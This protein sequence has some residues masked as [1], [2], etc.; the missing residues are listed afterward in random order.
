MKNITIALFFAI[1]IMPFNIAIA[2]E[3]GDDQTLSP[4]FYV[5]TEGDETENLP[6]LHTEADVNISGVIADVKITQIYKNTGK[7]PIEAIYVFPASTRAAV[8]NMKMTLDERVIVAQIQ[9]RTQARKTYEKAK[10]AGKSAS[11]LE[12]QRPNVFQMNIANIL[13]NDTIKVE[14]FYTETLVPED[15]VYEFVYPTV[16]GPRYSNQPVASAPASEKWIANPYLEEG[17]LPPYTF[18]IQTKIQTGIPIQSVTC[19]SHKVNIDFKAK[20]KAHIQLKPEDKSRGNKDYILKYALKGKR[21]QNGLLL[22]EG[23][24]ENFFMMMMQPPKR[25][26]SKSIPP[27]EYIFIMDVSGS[28]GGFPLDVSKKMMAEIF[29]T[30]RS[31]DIFN[32]VFF[33]G[34]SSVL[35]EESLPA[36]PD[37][38]KKANDMLKSLRGGGSTRLLPALQNAMSMTPSE[39]YSRSFVILTD[40]YI[41]VEEQAFD[42]IQDN[43]G[44][45]NFF[46]F[47]IGRSVNRF[48]LEGMARV[49][50]GEP[51]IITNKS[52]AAAAAERFKNYILSP[53]L[54]NIRVAFDGFEAYDI[55]PRNAP[56][57]FAERPL[58]VYGKYKGK[59]KGK[60]VISGKTGNKAFSNTINVANTDAT[61][62]N[63]ALTYLWARKK[64][65]MLDD[66]AGV[67][68]AYSK[69]QDRKKATTELG[70]KYNL[71]TR[72]TSFV[73]VDEKVRTKEPSKTVTQPLP[74]PEGVSNNAIPKSYMKKYGSVSKKAPKRLNRS[75]PKYR[76]SK[77]S[78]EEPAVPV[79][80]E[81][82]E[83]EAIE[84]IFTIVEQM[85]T[86]ASCDS[87][88][89][90]AKKKQCTE[91]TLMEYI[92]NQLEARKS[93]Y[94]NSGVKGLL[95]ISF[96]IDKTGAVKNVRVIKEIGGNASQVAVDIIKKMPL[97][98]LPGRQRS[99]PVDVKYNIPIRIR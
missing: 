90:N 87:L 88:A 15:G 55:E 3:N 64:I 61:I 62:D 42:Y 48:L 28:M 30:L 41:S 89:T 34:G 16:V 9:E 57:L 97:K 77:G 31:K 13:P 17:E 37:N 52:E 60:I 70:L 74:L 71:L 63:Q 72:Y 96:T 73:A 53:V 39:N 21:I 95:V 24:D 4:Y 82:E 33:A 81:E 23:K 86:L 51:F 79:F 65:Q 80:E 22:Y 1:L 58:L 67:S 8:Y 98:W 92:N 83:E 26:K 59:P 56:D 49:G 75:K 2:Q 6:L 46:T 85:P 7:K 93:E 54:Q 32:I 29:S 84:E 38:I 36:T 18:D 44:N 10:K 91:K 50:Y 78:D 43:L 69:N 66:Y 47:G 99:R 27:R 20:D 14:L 35:S 19:T 12:Q 25:I 40:G 5:P 94:N 45:A 68:D 76:N 11:L